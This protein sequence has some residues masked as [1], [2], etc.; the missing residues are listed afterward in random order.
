M[1]PEASHGK[2]KNGSRQHPLRVLQILPS[3]QGGGVERGTL[4][5]ARAI[6]AR[7]WESIVMSEGGRLVPQL[8]KEGSEHLAAPV[9]R[10]N[11]W[12]L[13]QV[14]RLIK[15]CRQRQIDILHARS[16]IPA[17]IA[18]FAMRCLP[19]QQRPIFVTTIHGLHSVNWFSS[20]MARGDKV[21]AVSQT[22]SDYV[23]RHYS[24]LDSSRLHLVH[25]GV[26]ATEFPRDYKPDA[27]WQQQWYDDFPMLRNAK[28][29][30]LPG[31]ITRRK[32]HLEFLELIASMRR[33][34]D[35]VVGLIVGDWE[36]RQASL[37]KAIHQRA[38]AL[39]IQ[40]YLIWTGHR[41]DMKSIYAS[42]DLTLSLSNKPESFGRSILEPL[43]LG[44]RCAGL[45]HGGVG[46]VLS[47]MFPEGKLDPLA[48]LE[49]WTQQ[50][51]GLMNETGPLPRANAF[52]LSESLNRELNLYEFWVGEQS[53]P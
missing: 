48:G 8:L 46:E 29:V 43:C 35:R 19:A 32:G 4:E 9:G 1:N 37:I 45:D 50:C 53:F 12:V 11:P 27:Q 7:G 52:L 39:G 47:Q 22:A 16:R 17:W 18:W 21:I 13:L 51:L 24:S 26:T 40:D 3:L 10:K 20:I 30:C 28:V 6:V 33:I 25:R 2:T 34:D 38:A 42:T 41:N 15:V 44:K 36:P 31:R 5:V 49:C 14:F 23:L